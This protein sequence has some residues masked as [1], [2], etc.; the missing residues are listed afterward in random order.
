MYPV[1]P[2]SPSLIQ[3]CLDS[4]AGQLKRLTKY[5]IFVFELKNLSKHFYEKERKAVTV[6]I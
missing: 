6:R 3:G 1:Y 2:I 4:S 5:I